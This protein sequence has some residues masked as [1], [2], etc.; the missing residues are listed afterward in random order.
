MSSNFFVPAICSGNAES[1]SIAIT[2][3]D[4]PVDGKT[5][6]LLTILKVNEVEAC[7]FFIRQNIEKY[8]A[9]VQK[10]HN[11]GHII[12]N[13]SFYHGWNFDL[14]SS[15]KMKAELSKTDD[16]IESILAKRPNFFRPPYGVT[17]PNLT[18]AVG[19]DYTTI[20]WSVRS[21]DTVIK[22]P[23]KLMMRV[24]RELKGG[25][26]VLFHDNS[27]AMLEVLPEFIKHVQSIGLKIVR[28]DRL[29]GENPYTTEA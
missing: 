1:T 22:D 16:A 11:E 13:H 4:G 17:N 19:K 29:I 26:I 20:G 6:K 15:K 10:I 5:Q 3:D 21:F 23:V 28:L 9:L 25:D 7:F 27:D 12:G 18:K 14:L 24:T 8:Q 2:F